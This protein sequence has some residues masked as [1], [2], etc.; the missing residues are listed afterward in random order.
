V[1]EIPQPAFLCTGC[2]EKFARL[3]GLAVHARHSK[4][5]TREMRFWGKVD[6]SGGPDACWPWQGAI[7]SHG[8]G[9]FT[10]G[11]K[12]V[13]G[14]HKAAYQYA[15]GTLVPG[16]FEIMHS[17]DN[18]PCCNPRHL[19]TGTRQDNV[20]DKVRKGRQA[21]RGGRKLTESS[22]REIRSLRGIEGSG[23]LAKRFGVDQS[24]IICIW[25]RR[26]WKHVG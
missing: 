19:S 24:H 10:A 20:D 14:A 9:C 4:T 2:G 8:Y 11:G 6:K 7:T 13:M 26:T 22:V 23:S 15:N 16:G 1:T 3:W 5:C 17:C 21:K 12:R 25:N 18:R